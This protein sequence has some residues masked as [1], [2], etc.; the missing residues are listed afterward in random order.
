MPIAF[1]TVMVMVMINIVGSTEDQMI[2]NMAFV[3]VR[4]QYIRIF[5]FKKLVGQF[6]SNC[7]CL[8]IGNFSR[9]K[10]LYQIK[11][12]IFS[13]FVHWKESVRLYG[14]KV[15]GVVK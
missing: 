11:C 12:L 5:S 1:F 8:V 15:I 13:V 2:V 3:N 10:R 6:F 4:G 9:S 14:A 7:M